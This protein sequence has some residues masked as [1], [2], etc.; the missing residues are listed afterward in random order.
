MINSFQL[1]HSSIIMDELVKEKKC[2][3]GGRIGSGATAKV[4]MGEDVNDNIIATKRVNLTKN[5]RMLLVDREISILKK[6]ST[7]RHPNVL[8]YRYSFIS[9]NEC[10][11]YIITNYYHGDSLSKFQ[12]CIKK[13]YS[14]MLDLLIQLIEGLDFIHKHGIIHADIKLDN[15]IVTQKMDDESIVTYVPILL[16]FGLSHD[17]NG[18]IPLT[19]RGTPK[20]VAPEIYEQWFN[21]AENLDIVT[22]K[23]DV[24]ALGL[25]FYE[26][27][28]DGIWPNLDFDDTNDFGLYVISQCKEFIIDTSNDKLNKLLQN[29]I[30]Y[31]PEFRYDA[32][33]LLNLSKL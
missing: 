2:R 9:S 28:N 12:H 10:Y 31:E 19:F 25:C 17:I 6:I 26:I 22:T 32:Q 15:I 30:I 1:I 7:N 3:I 11:M 20:Y 33:Q 16:D 8:H 5:F 18:E 14:I 13:Q 27:L 24:W 4:Y 23:S 29:M 21:K